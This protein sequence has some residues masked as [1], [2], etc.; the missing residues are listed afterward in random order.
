MTMR[1]CAAKPISHYHRLI[2]VKLDSLLQ[3]QL[4][5]KHTSRSPLR[6][7][8]SLNLVLPLPEQ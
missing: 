1:A 5:C 2:S 4:S 3:E 7:Y 6:R 8:V